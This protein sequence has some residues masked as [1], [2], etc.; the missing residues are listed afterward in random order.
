MQMNRVFEK[1]YRFRA[2]PER[3]WQALTDPVQVGRWMGTRVVAMELRPGGRFEVEGLYPGEI[4]EIQPGRRLVWA[5]DPDNGTQPMVETLTL[6]EEDGGTRLHVHVLAQG[7]WAENLMHFSGVEAG[8]QGW[9]EALDRWIED[10]AE[11]AADGGGTL[12]AS[13]S[14]E[15][16]GETH[17]LFFLKLKPGGV[18]EAAG[19]QVGDSLRVWNGRALDRVP[20]FWSLFWKA[21]PGEQVTLGLERDGEPFTVELTLAA[22]P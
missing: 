13:L 11:P 10:G 16:L 21:A 12:D 19:I 4:R 20:T 17:R 18:S 6:H 1:E 14:A 15:D 8:W 2:S 5:W 22:R 3:V 9:L 7:R